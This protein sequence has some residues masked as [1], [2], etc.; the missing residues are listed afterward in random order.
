MRWPA[1]TLVAMTVL[2]ALLLAGAAPAFGDYTLTVSTSPSTVTYPH[3]SKVVVG[4][5]GFASSPAT[6]TMQ[7]RRVDGGEWTTWSRRMI[8]AVRSAEATSYHFTATPPWLNETTEFRAVVSG[9][10]T[11][12]VATVTVAARIVQPGAI[13]SKPRKAADRTITF[14]GLIWPAHLKGTDV[15]TL[16][17]WKQVGRTWVEQP[18]LTL[19]AKIST[20]RYWLP[21]TGRQRDHA[22]KWAVAVPISHFGNPA[23]RT[24]WQVQASHEDTAHAAS[25]SRPN[26]FWIR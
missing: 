3:K 7:Y 16:T 26:W 20:W 17:F 13:L 15:V 18:D 19:T 10:A 8:S 22:S 1:K 25:Q 9:E 11:S 6:I 12:N 21:W 5:D 14:R 2:V 24:R 4:L 23:N